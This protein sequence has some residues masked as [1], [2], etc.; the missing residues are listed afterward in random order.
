ML[1]NPLAASAPREVQ[2]DMLNVDVSVIAA[3]NLVPSTHKNEYQVFTTQIRTHT[4]LHT[5]QCTRMAH[6]VCVFV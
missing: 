6:C 4:K 3:R 2:G 5:L 1:S